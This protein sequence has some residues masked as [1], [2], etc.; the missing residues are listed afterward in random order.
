MNPHYS[1]AVQNNGWQTSGK[2]GSLRFSPGPALL[3][4]CTVLVLLGGA[5]LILGSREAPERVWPN[6][7]LVSFYVLTLG[8][9]GLVFVALQYVSGA[10]WSVGLRRVPEAMIVGI[11]L[12]TVG[13]VLLFLVKPSLYPW[14]GVP[15]AEASPPLRRIWYTQ[16]FF[17]A[18]AAIYIA[19]WLALGYALVWTSRRQDQDHAI[20]YTRQNVRWSAAFLV[21]FALTFWLACS[22][23]LMSLEPDWSSTMFAVYQF[24]GLFLAGLAGVVVLSALLYWLG[25]FRAVLTKEHVHDLGKLLFG[26]STFWMYLWLF[27][28]MLIWYVNNPEET[29][30]FTRRLSGGWRTLFVLNIVLNWAIPFLVLLPRAMKRQIVVL[31]AVS[32][33]ILAGRWLDLYLA[34]LPYTGEPTPASLVWEA[35]LLVGAAGLFAL[36]FFAALGQAAVIP[37]GDPFLC[38]SLASACEIQK[39]SVGETPREAKS[40]LTG[41]LH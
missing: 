10:G 36:L 34:I 21:V 39:S 16:P 27:Q 29:G 12:A 33:I 24:G 11:P 17:L 31:T 35:G 19:C 20:A 1:A 4:F 38:E 8:L 28:Y 25:P 18:R 6:V 3:C 41:P 9:A 22:D 26:F 14:I 13:L 15:V 7:L 37:E 23:W 40:V 5:A 32:L 30:Y 2:P